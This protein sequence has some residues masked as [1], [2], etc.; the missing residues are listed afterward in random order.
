VYIGSHDADVSFCPGSRTHFQL[1]AR[2][3]CVRV[4]VRARV[5]VVRGR[6]PTAG[7]LFADS[8]QAAVCVC[9]AW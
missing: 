1:L 2:K 6:Q 7:C 5:C 9:C 8:K 3:V 4:R